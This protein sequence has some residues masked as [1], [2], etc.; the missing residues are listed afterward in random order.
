MHRLAITSALGIPLYFFPI[1]ADANWRN[2]H[3]ENR[4]RSYVVVDE[5][6]DLHR[7]DFNY[8]LSIDVNIYQTG[9][10]DRW[11]RF[12]FV[13]SR[14]CHFESR[15]TRGRYASQSFN[16]MSE[17][18]QQHYALLHGFGRNLTSFPVHISTNGFT[19]YVDNLLKGLALNV[20]SEGVE[21]AEEFPSDSL[22]V[23][24]FN[25]AIGLFAAA[26]STGISLADLTFDLSL[27]HLS[28]LVGIQTGVNCADAA[29]VMD[30]RQQSAVALE[31]LL[32]GPIVQVDYYLST[33]EVLQ[34]WGAADQ[35]IS[36][37]RAIFV[38]PGD[39][40]DWRDARMAPFVAIQAAILGA[41]VIGNNLTEDHLAEL[42]DI[43]SVNNSLL[44]HEIVVATALK[45]IVG[46]L[47]ARLRS[48][49][50]ELDFLVNSLSEYDVSVPGFF[51]DDTAA[52]GCVRLPNS[53]P[54]Y[55][56]RLADTQET[57]SA[58][59]AIWREYR[60]LTD[61]IFAEADRID[62][63]VR[64]GLRIEDEGL[65]ALIAG[66]SEQI[67]EYEAYFQP[68]ANHFIAKA[69]CEEIPRFTIDSELLQTSICRS[70]GCRNDLMNTSVRVILAPED[71]PRMLPSHMLDRSVCIDA[72]STAQV[73]VAGLC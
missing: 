17:S 36:P 71:R 39:P 19:E 14:D 11:Y 60:A 62:Q 53:D 12:D 72:S 59:R 13:D 31:R 2:A 4:E 26:I 47:D 68:I 67:D 30:L 48:R 54:I 29:P 73:A 52:A 70:G 44:A 21:L 55:M 8:Y 46:E 1:E 6:G 35:Y 37:R 40:E 20:I 22:E 9:D 45:I 42:A 23:E 16:L 10:V 41:E 18:G 56:S 51:T 38:Y 28:R 58:I 7:L 33:L 24:D 3:T 66:F 25:D 61:D 57:A 34:N 49:S 50:E 69:L 27:D 64:I 43:G 15:V 63:F 5:V 32:E 65:H